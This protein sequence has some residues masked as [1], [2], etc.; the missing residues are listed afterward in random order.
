MGLPGFI[1]FGLGFGFL[2]MDCSHEKAR[3]RSRRGRKS[4][5]YLLRMPQ[6]PHLPQKSSGWRE[7]LCISL[8]PDLDHDL[9]VVPASGF[10]TP[11][12]APADLTE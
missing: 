3:S 11:A 1:G 6:V 9:P 5:S 4:P 12:Y 2:D 7:M 8:R 10:V